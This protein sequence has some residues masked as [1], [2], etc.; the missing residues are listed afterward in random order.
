MVRPA[1]PLILLGAASLLTV[2]VVAG[3]LL[4]RDARD[5]TP[6]ERAREL[7]AVEPYDVGDS[8]H[9]AR[10][11]GPK[12]QGDAAVVQAQY[13]D[14]AEELGF[15]LVVVVDGSTARDVF[16]TERDELAAWEEEVQ[17][18]NT[19]A[20]SEYCARRGLRVRCVGFLPKAPLFVRSYGSAEEDDTERELDVLLL[21]RTARKHWYRV[22]DRRLA[23]HGAPE[24]RCQ[25]GRYAC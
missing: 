11:L 4:L 6:L 24:L 7:R 13:T 5:P 10:W 25:P 1:R 14:A 12:D 18:I 2:A 20:H 17:E 16:E 19:F 21:L 3:A 8:V 23:S 22:F 9:F 15:E